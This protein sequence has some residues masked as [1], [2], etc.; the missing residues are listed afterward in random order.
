M[1]PKVS[2]A[3]KPHKKRGGNSEPKFIVEKIDIDGD[4]TFDG[5]LIKRYTIDNQNNKHF[6]DQKFVPNDRIEEEFTRYKQE[7]PEFQQQQHIEQFNVNP[8]SNGGI[9][10]ADERAIAR[11]EDGAQIPATQ[12]VIMQDD[13]SFAQYVKQG[14]GVGAG[15]A[16][17]DIVKG[18]FTGE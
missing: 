16:V 15:F 7:H 17:V 4:G 13:T 9:K 8:R 5:V 1:T 11:L 3:K 12:R 14:V 18:F 2:N 6:L 10:V